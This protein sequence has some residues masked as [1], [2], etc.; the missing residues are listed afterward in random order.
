MF[1]E[2]GTDM[3]KLIALLLCLAAMGT[4]LAACRKDP[5][6]SGEA[7]S[8]KGAV[9]TPEDSG[10]QEG[11]GSRDLSDL[12]QRAD[13]KDYLP[14]D[15]NYG[16]KEFVTYSFKEQYEMDVQGTEYTGDVVKD[17]VYSRNR[18][19]EERLK[20]VIVNKRSPAKNFVDFAAEV[21]NIQ[22]VAPESYHAIFTMGNS[23]IQLGNFNLYQDVDDM[24]RLSLKSGWWWNQ[25]MQEVSFDVNHRK[26]LIGDICLS[27]YTRCG[28]MLV[29]L[30]DYNNKF[31]EEKIDGLYQLVQD[32]N[33]TMA[34]LK[35]RVRQ[36]YVDVDG[37]GV[38]LED[39]GDFLGLSL[40]NIEMIKFMEYAFDVK[41]YSRDADGCAILDYD[42]N[43]AVTAADKLIDLLF[44]DNEGVYWQ[45]GYQNGSEFAQGRTLFQV[46]WMSMLLSGNMAKMEKTY[47]IVPLPMLDEQQ[48]EYTTNVQNSSQMVGFLKGMQEVEFA[49]TVV[50]AMCTES[51][52]SVIFPFY[53]T[54][55]KIQYARESG[56]ASMIDIIMKTATKNFLY[57]YEAGGGCGVLISQV[58]LMESNQIVSEYGRR[59][60]T[61]SALLEK[62]KQ[63]LYPQK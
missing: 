14:E 52:R 45:E 56:I 8:T 17:L 11:D 27:N 53:E 31:P 47:T 1:P 19:V 39:S 25:A 10:R 26:F 41:R 3:K 61:T 46:S 28:V 12:S 22:Q 50:E 42:V 23:A 37:N 54:A 36:A 5:S 34:E 20:C 18:A 62:W 2:K 60:T 29:N 57:E 24:S 38:R 7:S 58:V 40:G 21:K 51:Y 49:S 9:T 16:G 43:R 15:L 55:L 44:D 33:W 4:S 30:T 32:R 63:D 6:S 48:K 13:T 35:A 59:A